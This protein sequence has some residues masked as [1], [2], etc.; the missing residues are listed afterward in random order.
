[1]LIL[2]SVESFIIDFDFVF[3]D[4][5]TVYSTSDVTVSLQIG[6]F[7]NLSPFHSLVKGNVLG[8][9]NDRLVTFKFSLDILNRSSTV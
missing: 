6:N 9:V 7:H 4:Y 2:K 1:M 5:C 3:S 8:P